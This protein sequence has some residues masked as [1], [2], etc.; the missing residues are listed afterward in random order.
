MA[1]H[2]TSRSRA[3]L[4]VLLRVSVVLV[5]LTIASAML[6]AIFDDLDPAEIGAAIKELS[7]GEWLALAFGWMVWVACQGAQTA[8]L[9]HHLPVRRGVLASLGPSAVASVVPGPSDLPVKFR[10]FQSWG[11]SSGDAATAVATNGVFS[12]G[13]QLILPAIAG[14]AIFFGG[15]PLQGFVSVIVAITLVLV[16]VI[17]A[18][19]FVLG[20]ARRTA[21]TADRFEWLVRAGR[22][23]LRKPPSTRPL[24]DAVVARRAESL[25]YLRGKWLGATLATVV[26]VA[27]KLSLLLMALRFAGVP[28]SALGWPAV[29]AVYALVAGITTVPIS[30]GSAGV[31][32]VAYVG[33]LTPIAG[34]EWANA[35][36]AGVLLFR[37]LTWILIIPAGLVALGV[38]RYGDRS[39]P[40]DDPSSGEP[41]PAT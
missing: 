5:A 32:E 23:I 41:S 22:R 37:L 31:A 1:D 26:T 19:G 17:V 9:V 27:A 7:D 16:V 13:S 38:W 8:S 40:S 3:A 34:Q 12:V 10:M 6:L 20:S 2:E 11:V 28:E 25:E 36:A 35:V 33:M 24:A 14:L 30:P 18:G 15:I 39:R 21:W 4:K 29:F